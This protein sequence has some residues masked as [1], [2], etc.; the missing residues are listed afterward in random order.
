[1]N[2]SESDE[3]NL[4]EES[5][6]FELSPG[7]STFLTHSLSLLHSTSSKKY[8]F[9]KNIKIYKKRTILCVCFCFFEV[10]EDPVKNEKFQR[11]G[12]HEMMSQDL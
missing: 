1:M 9:L 11:L 8:S 7:L 10:C 4:P 2:V 6:A 5:N 3:W 12:D